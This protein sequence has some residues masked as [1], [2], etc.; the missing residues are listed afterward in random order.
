MR[1]V[2][3]LASFLLL[4]GCA[5]LQEVYGEDQA[6]GGGTDPYEKI[7][8]D[9]EV[10]TAA[11]R[12]ECEAA[13]GEVRRDGMLGWQQCVQTYTDAGK[14]C[15]DNDDCLGQCRLNIGETMPQPDETVTGTCQASDS[16]F[17]CYATVEDGKAT[18]TICVD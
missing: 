15:S 5:Y 1:R 14:T 16:P 13:G 9:G 12:A 6:Y 18:P 17:G 2:L 10:A 7:S 11:E 8:F 4:A 3:L